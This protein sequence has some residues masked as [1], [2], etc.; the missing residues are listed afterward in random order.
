ME[1]GGWNQI[2]HIVHLPHDS[3][4][5]VVAQTDGPRSVMYP[6]HQVAE[7]GIHEVLKRTNR[8]IQM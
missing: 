1:Y 6:S 5:Q 8:T 2:W 7:S 4:R 3:C